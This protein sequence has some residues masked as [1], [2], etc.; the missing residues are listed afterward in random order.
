[1]RKKLDEIEKSI[2]L[3]EKNA[4]SAIDQVILDLS[5]DPSPD[6][7]SIHSSKGGLHRKVV[8]I[9]ENEVKIRLD[10]QFKRELIATYRDE[11]ERQVNS[12]SSRWNPKDLG[13]ITEAKIYTLRE[14]M[15][16][17]P[18]VV[19]E[20][21]WDVSCDKCSTHPLH[22]DHANIERLLTEGDLRVESSSLASR[23]FGKHEV[24]MTL[25]N[26]VYEYLV[27]QLLRDEKRRQTP[28]KWSTEG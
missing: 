13:V 25:S 21:Q 6:S 26:I 24:K 17:N 15:H 1:M 12:L 2:P 4:L 8:N 3:L 16:S 9:L 22:L 23:L 10:K 27:S 14:Q 18:F 5:K 19:P 11:V 28:E 7:F 20:G